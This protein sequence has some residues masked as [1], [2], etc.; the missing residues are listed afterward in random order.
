VPECGGPRDARKARP[1]PEVSARVAV[2]PLLD[3]TLTV[4]GVSDGPAFA[5]H[6]G[7][8]FPGGDGWVLPRWPWLGLLLLVFI[9]SPRSSG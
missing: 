9:G 7:C 8:V 6:D 1:R 3:A 4:A 5:Y 2:V